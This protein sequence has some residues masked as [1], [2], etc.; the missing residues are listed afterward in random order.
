MNFEVAARQPLLP[1]EIGPDYLDRPLPFD[2]YNHQGVLLA[3]RGTVMDDLGRLARM[4]QQRLYRPED[5]SQDA[6]PS[7]LAALQ[8]IAEDYGNLVTAG[9]RMDVD[10]LAELALDL[11]Q[12]VRQHPEICIGMAQRL[13]LKS[14][15]QRHALFVASVAVAMAGRAGLERWQQVNIARAALSMNLV[16]MSLQD[17]LSTSATPPDAGQLEALFQHPLKARALLLQAGVSDAAW[18]DLVA[19]HHENMDGSGYPQ[20][21]KGAQI[22]PEAR[23]LRAADVWCALLS[24]R[25]NRLARYPIQAFAECFERERGRLDDAMLWALR[26]LLG[27]YPP[28]TL[29]RLANRE[30][31]VITRWFGNPHAP[32]FAVS[33]LRSNGLPLAQPQK[34]NTTATSFAIRGYTFLPL[35]HAP[36][37]WERAWALG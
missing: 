35:Y 5:R 34:R 9:S 30:T 6:G 18:L 36:I 4:S 29:V 7:P 8:G 26:H 3:R 31:A 14:L 2:L 32:G 19:H 23:I 1:V 28:G 16:S 12:L 22:S 15:A 24:Q 37:D 21:L 25:H 20:G 17:Q 27:S 33:L 11:R 10:R 13:P